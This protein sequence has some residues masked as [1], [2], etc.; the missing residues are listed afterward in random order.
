LVVW[1]LDRLGRGLAH[2]IES[3]DELH[4]REVGFRS[5]TEAIDTTTPPGRLQFHI[6]G[7]LA[8]FRARDGPGAYPRRPG[9]CAGT[10][11]VGFAAGQR[12]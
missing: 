1:G 2:L 11:A 3:I 9:R 10:L 12:R 7:A 6:F 4:A 8:E 5:L